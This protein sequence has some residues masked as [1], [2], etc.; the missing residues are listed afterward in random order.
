[1]PA[2]IGINLGPGNI[3][4][5]WPEA[6]EIN[7]LVAEDLNV[8]VPDIGDQ[9]LAVALA[10]NIIGT[11]D[12]INPYIEIHSPSDL[13]YRASSGLEKAM[14]DTD[15]LRLMATYAE[16]IIDQWDPYAISSENLP[17]LAF[18]TGV[19]LWEADWNDA[20]RRWWVANQWRLME[21][22]GSLL[23][24]TD[25]VAAV[26]QQVMR[27]TVPPAKFIAGKSLT[28]DER[29]QYN[30]RFAQLRLYPYVARIQLPWLCY[31]S[32]FRVGLEQKRRYTNNGCFLGPLWKMYPTSADAGGRY[33]RTATIW[34]RGV[35]T[36][37]TVRTVSEVAIGGVTTTWDE[38]IVPAKIANHYYASQKGKWPLPKGH[39]IRWNKYG[40]F[41][42]IME[43]TAKR[44]I[45]IP[46]NGELDAA[47]AKMIYQTIVP[48]N[49]YISVYPEHVST[50]HPISARRLYAGAPYKRPKQF[51]FNKF[52][53][54]NGAFQYLYEVWYIFDPS[55]VPDYRRASVYMNH[56]RFG[57]HKYTAEIKIKILIQWRKWYLYNGGF[58]RGHL[59][60]PDTREIEKCRRAVT[61]SMAVRDTVGIDTVVKRRINTNDSLP[62]DGTF[63]VGQYIDA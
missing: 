34:D 25:Y 29:K 12:K 7:H 5:A 13:L 1:L 56:A 44:I 26:G 31:C 38:V 42:G 4:V 59:H 61:A 50:P 40:I 51:L 52:L 35:E 37:I 24:T 55:R 22:R 8:W 57:I 47:T 36:P 14:A 3:V 48:D 39:P 18:A 28:D 60:P 20:Q 11:T 30:S 58:F 23:G 21:E 62:C 54:T 27:A 6:G 19:N 32:N 43:E 16:L 46:R 10:G 53:P 17:Y 45:K 15:G 9:P 2:P 41:L 33:T 63:T 49:T